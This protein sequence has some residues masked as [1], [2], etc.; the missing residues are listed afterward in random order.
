LVQAVGHGGDVDAAAAA[1][2]AAAS[3]KNPKLFSSTSTSKSK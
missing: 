3:L 1:L 2:L